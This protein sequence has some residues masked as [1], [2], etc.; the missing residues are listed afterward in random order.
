MATAGIVAAVTLAAAV[1][2]PALAR[3]IPVSP[4][5]LGQILTRARPG[6]RLLLAPGRYRGAI[7]VRVPGLVIEGGGRAIIDAGGHGRVVTVDAP[8]VT[9]MGLVVTGSGASLPDEDSGIFLTARAKA[10]RIIA[11][12]LVD[13][14]I[15]INVKGAADAVVSDNTIIG[16]PLPR[17]NDRGNGIQLWNAPGTRVEHNA[18]EQ[19]R[20]GIFVTTSRHNV[21]AYNSFRRLR[22]AVHYMYTQDSAVIGNL[23]RGNHVGYALMYSYRIRAIANRSFGDRDHGLMLN[24]VSYSDIRDNWVRDVPGK[25]LFFYNANINRLVGN[26]FE[27]CGIGIHF[28]AGSERNEITGNAFIANRRQVKYVGTRFLDWSVNGRGNYWSDLEAFDLDG[29]GIADSA[30][31]PN[32]IVDRLLWST[33]DARYFLSSPAFAVLRMV[34]TQL[35][36]VLI[37]GVV[38]TAPLMQPPPLPPYPA[39][40]PRRSA[41]GDHRTSG[42]GA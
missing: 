42:A 37:G 20:D 32:D 28:T 38:D 8:E 27:H 30:Y 2:M 23:S 24:Y 1:V 6:D 3:D 35:P 4:A 34:S 19:V 41:A 18:V 33:P 10:A 21:F 16:R 29:D 9:L 11:N 17:F 31:R 5:A 40:G 36:P 39:V 14:L 13:N 25:C 22:F 7:V 26:R 12:H 15:G